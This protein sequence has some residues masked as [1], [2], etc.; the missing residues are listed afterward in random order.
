V[1]PAPGV[2]TKWGPIYKAEFVNRL[3]FAGEPTCYAYMGYME[4]ALSS[5]YRVAA[6]I[7]VRDEIGLRG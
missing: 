2:V 3:H 5:G 1:T 4:G 7:A 6:R